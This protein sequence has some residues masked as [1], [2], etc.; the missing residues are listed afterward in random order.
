MVSVNTNGTIQSA[1]RLAD[2]TKV[3]QTTHVALDG[4]WPFF[5]APYAGRGSV[6]G[7]LRFVAAGN[8]DVNGRVSWIRPPITS[9]PVYPAGFEMDSETFGNRFHPA[10]GKTNRVIAITAGLL[11][12][13]GGNLGETLLNNFT[14]GLNNKITN[15]GPHKLVMTLTNNTGWFSGSLTPVGTKQPIKFK[16][17]IFQRSNAVSFGSGYFLRGNLSGQVRIEPAP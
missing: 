11:T 14:V 9:S 13:A 6:L 15:R 4:S 5:A 16:G 3:T 1:W 8:A 7:W 12:L 2:G 17:A 10:V